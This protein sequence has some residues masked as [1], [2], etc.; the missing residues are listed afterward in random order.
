M[1]IIENVSMKRSDI[2]ISMSKG[3]P[4]EFVDNINAHLD[5]NKETDNK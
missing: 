4:K 5:V 2:D 3:Y 1:I